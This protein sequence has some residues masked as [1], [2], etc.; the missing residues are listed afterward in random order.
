M[1]LK[2]S[3]FRRKQDYWRLA[4]A[5]YRK[6]NGR[7]LSSNT[8]AVAEALQHFEHAQAGPDQGT[9]WPSRNR[10]AKAAEIG[11]KPET[12]RRE[13]SKHLRTLES[14]GFIVKLREGVAPTWDSPAV[15]AKWRLVLPKHEEERVSANL[16]PSDRKTQRD[17]VGDKDGDRAPNETG[18]GAQLH[19]Q[20][21]DK[22]LRDNN[23]RKGTPELAANA[24]NAVP[25]TIPTPSGPQAIETFL[26][27]V[28]R[29]PAETRNYYNY[30]AK[31]EGFKVPYETA[32][33][34]FSSH[35]AKEN[36]S[37]WLGAFKYYVS[38]A[39]TGEESTPDGLG[40]AADALADL[41]YT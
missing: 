36:R 29:F 33:T 7:K 18:V 30:L 27:H 17:R 28:N 15:T 24:R 20:T 11:G 26:D 35:M 14:L 1:N 3:D 25:G 6:E 38:T 39:M 41:N 10:I 32:L 5:T 8:I 13:V 4:I 19:T 37:N 21:L 16:E 23:L 22:N 31:K 40:M 34:V 9:C 12:Q 2:P